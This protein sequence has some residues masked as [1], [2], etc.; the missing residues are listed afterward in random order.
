M[1]VILDYATQLVF[2]LKPTIDAI[3]TLLFLGEYR[4]HMTAAGKR[5]A[6]WCLRMYPELVAE[7][8]TSG[9][10]SGA[11]LSRNNVVSIAQ[12]SANAYPAFIRVQPKNKA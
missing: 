12:Q 11:S 1:N 2:T 10:H 4:Q 3:S 9:T 5:I 7:L 8:A 6:L